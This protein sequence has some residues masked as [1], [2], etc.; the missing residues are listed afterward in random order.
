MQLPPFER[1]PPAGGLALLRTS[2]VE[3]IV[4]VPSNNCLIVCES[5]QPV[6]T[7]VPLGG[8]STLGG[9]SAPPPRQLRGHTA[10]VLCAEAVP[11][12]S[13]LV[14]GAADHS[15]C[16]WDLPEHGA[17]TLPGQHFRLR[18]R[19]VAAHAPLA[20]RWCHAARLLFSG[21]SD[22]AVIPWRLRDGDGAV[23][24]DAPL[25]G[26]HKA[27]VTCLAML[28]APYDDL[29]CSTSLDKTARLWDT[30]CKPPRCCH[31]ARPF[32]G[33]RDAKLAHA[34][35]DCDDFTARVVCAVLR[36]HTR[37]VVSA[38]F[39]EWRGLLFTAGL[40]SSIHVWSALS[41]TIIATLRAHTA[42]LV[43]IVDMSGA[44]YV[45]SADASGVLHLWD[46][47]STTQANT[48]HPRPH[49]TH[50]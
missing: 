44:P 32:P 27:A 15:L 16:W 22:G 8:G 41:E 25:A 33:P 40:D 42:P 26:G 17:A 36:G 1:A 19:V 9:A 5:P 50:T 31:G 30:S 43:E 29:L 14:T 35:T 12:A 38:A 39:S 18:Q 46:V 21:G 45:A 11:E 4:H 6:V 23:I 3:R 28:K 7:C 37:G 10:E 34:C 2:A 49:P 20:L 24:A 13:C 47:R 48:P